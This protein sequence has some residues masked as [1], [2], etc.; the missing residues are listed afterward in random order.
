MI[1]TD[2]VVIKTTKMQRKLCFRGRR[3]R[4]GEDSEAGDELE[5]KRTPTTTGGA[6]EDRRRRWSR[7]R[8]EGAGERPERRMAMGRGGGTASVE[9]EATGCVGGGRRPLV[10]LE[11][12][13]DGPELATKQGA[14]RSR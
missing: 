12:E 1:L 3:R 8:E 14:A 2:S 9:E 11:S 4:V 10:G 5:R 13:E 7:R 6:R